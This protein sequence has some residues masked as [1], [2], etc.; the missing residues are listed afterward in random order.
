MEQVAQ[1][2]G[3]GPH[4]LVTLILEAGQQACGW[5]LVAGIRIRSGDHVSR[6]TRIRFVSELAAANNTDIYY[7]Y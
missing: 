4:F 7:L 2:A 3:V 6:I 1:I 5:C